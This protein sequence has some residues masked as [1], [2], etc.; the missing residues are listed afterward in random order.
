MCEVKVANTNGLTEREVAPRHV[1]TWCHP[2]DLN[3]FPGTSKPGGRTDSEPE[4]HGGEAYGGPNE[5]LC[6]LVMCLMPFG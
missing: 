1:F 5:E 2:Y 3:G 6:Q 4:G